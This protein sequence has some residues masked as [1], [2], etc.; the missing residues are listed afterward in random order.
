MQGVRECDSAT[1]AQTRDRR[2]MYLQHSDYMF[3]LCCNCSL[4]ADFLTFPTTV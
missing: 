2:P 4:V 1:V 3:P